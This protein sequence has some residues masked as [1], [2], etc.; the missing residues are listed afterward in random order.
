[1]VFFEIVRNCQYS[2]N[3]ITLTNTPM[4]F[5]RFIC[6]SILHMSLIDEVSSG[7]NFMKYSVNHQYKF[8]N[9]FIPWSVGMMQFA[10]AIGVETSNIGVLCCALDPINLVFNFIAL[11]IVAE[12]DNYVFESLKNESIKVLVEKKFYKRVIVVNHTTSK[13]CKLDELSSVKDENGDFRPLRITFESR[14]PLNMILFSL[15]KFMRAFYV[16]LF[17]YFLPFSAIMISTL[18]PIIYR[19]YSPPVCTNTN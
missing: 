19:F 3:I 17:Y 9:F 7:L 13:K 11:A 10:S 5:G 15:Y 16:S 8:N 18:L 6:A 12:F 1:M 4:L 2:Y 14:S